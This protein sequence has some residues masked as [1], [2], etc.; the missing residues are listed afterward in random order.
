VDYTYNDAL[1]FN[2]FTLAPPVNIASANG[3][4][5][6]IFATNGNLLTGGQGNPVVNEFTTG[7]AFVTDHFAGTASFHLALSPDGTKVYTSTFGG[8][9]DTVTL[10][11]GNTV[12][13][14]SGDD[15][16][17]TQL[18]FAH[19]KVFYDD[20]SPNGFGNAGLYDLGTNTTTRTQTGAR[21]IHGMIYDP[22]SDRIVFFG[23]GAVGSMDATTGTGYREFDATGVGDF[24]QG[25]VDGK[26]HT[27]VA[28][29]GGIT[30]IDYRSSGELTNPSYIQYVGG[31]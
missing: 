9:L 2:R 26:G 27:F 21:P 16:G 20:G 6:I 19:G 30:V 3:A 17:V 10:A 5:G 1:A 18:A 12:S 29:S 28:G 11:G 7:G 25:A 8:P 22:Y 23:A 15:G 14:V 4:D 24:D 13:P 31:L